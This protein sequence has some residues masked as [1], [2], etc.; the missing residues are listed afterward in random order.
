MVAA[1][2]DWG[3]VRGSRGQQAAWGGGHGPD[4][5]LCLG[6]LHMHDFVCWRLGVTD[7]GGYKAKMGKIFRKFNAYEGLEN[8]EV[9][10][11]EWVV[12][13]VLGTL[14]VPDRHNERVR[15]DTKR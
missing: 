5:R 11:G 4:H 1:R 10:G 2:Q 7:K 6:I 8:T 13:G 9:E 12:N 14:T 3:L 15:M